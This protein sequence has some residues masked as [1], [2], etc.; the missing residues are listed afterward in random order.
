M[1]ATQFKEKKHNGKTS[2]YYGRRSGGMRSCCGS[3]MTR[4]ESVTLQRLRTFTPDD[5][6]AYSAR[7]EEFRR[8]LCGAQ[9]AGCQQSLVDGLRMPGEWGGVFPVHLRF[10][11]RK[12]RQ[13][14]IDI[15]SPGSES[16]FW[17]GLGWINPDHT[18]LYILNTKD[19]EPETI[20]R[21]LK[22]V[23]DMVTAGIPAAEIVA[24]LGR[25]GGRA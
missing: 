20:G 11:P 14:T 4:D 24:V 7:G 13:V 18:G 10:T 25:K 17:H 21:L 2:A 12:N 16:P 19:F 6:E 5:F 3:E 15:L 8:R 1:S 23:E 9:C 22:R